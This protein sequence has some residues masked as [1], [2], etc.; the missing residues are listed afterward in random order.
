MNQTIVVDSRYAFVGKVDRVV[1][2][3]DGKTSSEL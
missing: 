3:R 1:N 2:I